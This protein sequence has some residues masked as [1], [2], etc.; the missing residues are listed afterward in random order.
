MKVIATAAYDEFLNT[1]NSALGAEGGASDPSSPPDPEGYNVPDLNGDGRINYSDKALYDKQRAGDTV[2]ENGV[3]RPKGF[4]PL[5][6]ST[7][8][9]W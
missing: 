2:D 9:N 6:P 1:L 4:D 7:W 8:F 3:V 5:D